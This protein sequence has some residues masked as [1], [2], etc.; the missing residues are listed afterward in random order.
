[1]NKIQQIEV[2][3]DSIK[4]SYSTL[5]NQQLINSLM[6]I[7]T[8][9][10]QFLSKR[11]IQ[12]LF[13]HNF[14]ILNAQSTNS[15]RHYIPKD[16]NNKLEFITNLKEFFKLIN[17]DIKTV[18]LSTNKTP[19]YF[20][21]K[22]Y[23]SFFNFLLLWDNLWV[24]FPK[25]YYKPVKDFINGFDIYVNLSE[26]F[27]R[28]IFGD[29]GIIKSNKITI[30][31]FFKNILYYTPQEKKED[32]QRHAFYKW[33]DE[34]FLPISVFYHLI[35]SKYSNSFRNNFFKYIISIKIGRTSE[36]NVL[37]K[38]LLDQIRNSN[39]E[40]FEEVIPFS[41]SKLGWLFIFYPKSTKSTFDYLGVFNQ[42][43]KNKNPEDLPS[44]DITEDMKRHL[45]MEKTSIKIV[46]LTVENFKSL[47]KLEILFQDS[48][49]IIYG[50]NGSGKTSI[51]HSILFALFMFNDTSKELFETSLISSGKKYT[52]VKI[53]IKRENELISIER[54]LSIDKAQEITIEKKDEKFEIL[55]D[56]SN[57]SINGEVKLSSNNIKQK[58]FEK[59]DDEYMRNMYFPSKYYS[60]IVKIINR[61]INDFGLYLNY[62]EVFLAYFLE[63][64]H[65]E[66]YLKE[67]YA[68]SR[69]K[70]DDKEFLTF[71]D[72]SAE[73]YSDKFMLNFINQIT[74]H[75]STQSNDIDSQ[76]TNILKNDF[77]PQELLNNINN[78][79]YY[80]IKVDKDVCSLHGG[81]I[82]KP[83][84]ICHNCHSKYCEEC[85]M[86]M[87]ECV[88]CREPIVQDLVDYNRRMFKIE[89]IMDLFEEFNVTFMPPVFLI[90]DK[91]LAEYNLKL[92]SRL[93]ERIYLA[94]QNPFLD[95]FINFFNYYFSKPKKNDSYRN[96]RLRRLKLFIRKTKKL[97]QYNLINYFSI[98][99]FIKILNY[100]DRISKEKKD[101]F[102]KEFREI[103]TTKYKDM[104]NAVGN[105]KA[106]L[107]NTY[108]FERKIINFLS[109]YVVLLRS[110]L[111]DKGKDYYST[112]KE[113]KMLISDFINKNQPL[114]EDKGHHFNLYAY[115]HNLKIE[116]DMEY[117]SY[118][119]IRPHEI[120]FNI[121]KNQLKNIFI[122]L[123]KCIHIKNLE[124]EKE[125]LKNTLGFFQEVYYF[126]YKNCLEHLRKRFKEEFRNHFKN[127]SF[128]AFL[129]KAGIPYIKFKGAKETL[130]ITILSG[131]ER[132]KIL[133]L[134]FTLL[135]DF[136][137]QKNF[138]L[139]DEPNELL[140]P[141]NIDLVKKFFLKFFSDR[142]IVICT[143]I[144]KYKDFQPALVYN[145]WKDGNNISHVFQFDEDKEKFELYVKR[146]EIEK[147]IK[148]NPKDYYYNQ[149]KL[150]LLITLNLYEEAL[151]YFQ[152][153]KD[154]VLEVFNIERL[155]SSLL[156]IV[157]LD[158]VRKESNENEA[159]FYRTRA[160]LYY[161]LKELH[162]AIKDIDEAI[163]IGPKMPEIYDFKARSLRYANKPKKALEAIEEGIRLFPKYTG[164]Y[165]I[166]SEILEALGRNEEALQD[167]NKAIEIDN[168]EY[169]VFY[170]KAY[171]LNKLERY[172]EALVNVN[173]AIELE[174]HD[175]VL[176]QDKI[177]ILQNL[178]RIDEAIKLL[179]KENKNSVFSPDTYK[180]TKAQLLRDKAYNLME[181]G[182]KDEAIKTI[183]ETLELQP[184]WPE[185]IQPYGEI[186][187][188]F[189]EYEAAL[190]Q[191]E[192]ANSLPFR[193]L[194]TPIQIGICLYELG[195]YME[196]L[197][198]L[199][200]GKNS[201]QYSVKSVITTDDGKTVTIDAPQTELIEEAEKYILEV[202]KKL[203]KSKKPEITHKKD[204]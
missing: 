58:I 70:L 121:F 88:K 178:N 162:D 164:F 187:M 1:M 24:E 71:S 120:D 65:Y 61:K 4:K 92:Q 186:L 91:E 27:I 133:I 50:L 149:K 129:D 10:L 125:K 142:Q 36:E 12:F 176:S 185:Y 159:K 116:Y 67:E 104:Y 195:R 124:K 101:D 29:K 188:H 77:S 146:D 183:K 99:I 111:F 137:E 93:M 41:S 191:L 102:Y 197:E 150:V 48:I 193:P 157:K 196:A 84:A 35:N 199:N 80:S 32:Y 147:K 171:I 16:L 57:L 98:L 45:K 64:Y 8:D 33:R 11:I 155:E 54:K 161:D 132:N 123:K 190:E 202:E 169:W 154:L 108:P 130:P 144:D 52:K 74:N 184:D 139:I 113:D 39:S 107:L 198:N 166:K 97:D 106:T 127:E 63:Y 105:L 204:Q 115:L 141:D 14:V 31:K 194:K 90:R 189:G 180:Q 22:N 126:L 68:E 15:L 182:E 174:P 117:E 201:A 165:N 23:K 56:E 153:I 37:D 2:I 75:Y 134:I 95:Y 46:K 76:I 110:K 34:K 203:K 163:K 62:S 7:P 60:E 85:A 13:N 173:K 100:D 28:G 158:K 167:I 175:F 66:Y 3:L 82:L 109:I 83:G 135:N 96:V 140:D 38:N 49:N 40:V 25:R 131:A 89:E 94:I 30:T 26:D 42:F 172:E 179:N 181:S 18:E 138:F 86:L 53:E 21:F 69:E 73:V 87:D 51:L 9:D 47:G 136:S 143:Y 122:F 200:L 114:I 6:K 118:L 72:L 152:S 44:E 17:I 79:S 59:Y 148:K 78:N 145:V 19:T 43:L 20:Y 128:I 177:S 55:F 119:I 168:D 192:R 170:K 160:L 112:Q 81:V 103:I 151:K 5:D 156:N